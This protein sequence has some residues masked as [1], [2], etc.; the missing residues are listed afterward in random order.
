MLQFIEHVMPLVFQL[1]TMQCCGNFAIYS[2]FP[3]FQDTSLYTEFKT[4]LH[5]PAG[6]L[7]VKKA[8]FLVMIF[9]IIIISFFA[10]LPKRTFC[11]DCLY[12]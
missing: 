9:S 6:Y 10:Q 11:I 8:Y 12:Y 7:N 4:G 3:Y 1:S 2:S 5:F